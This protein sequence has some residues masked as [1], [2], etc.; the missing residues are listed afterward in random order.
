MSHTEA[1]ISKM[2]FRSD[3][4]LLILDKRNTDP[5][6]LPLV[7]LDRKPQELG[8]PHVPVTS[9]CRSLVGSLNLIGIFSSL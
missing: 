8:T 5:P 3:G 9:L 7:S 4:T 2:S 1:A 6:L